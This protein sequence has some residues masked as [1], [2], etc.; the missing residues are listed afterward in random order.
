MSAT[1][2][3]RLYAFQDWRL[4]HGIGAVCRSRLMS[5]MCY[6][7]CMQVKINVCSFSTTWLAL[8]VQMFM[9]KQTALSSKCHLALL[10]ELCQCQSE[11]TGTLGIQIVQGTLSLSV[12]QTVLN[13]FLA[14]PTRWTCNFWSEASVNMGMSGNIK[15]QFSVTSIQTPKCPCREGPGAALHVECTAILGPIWTSYCRG[16]SNVSAVSDKKKKETTT[17]RDPTMQRFLWAYRGRERRK[18][19]RTMMMPVLIQCVTLQVELRKLSALWLHFHTGPQDL[20]TGLQQWLKGMN[21]EPGC[22]SVNKPLDISD[23]WKR[24]LFSIVHKLYT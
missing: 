18:G 19:H 16:H 24:V 2:L 22:W 15:Q 12:A 14:H 23:L 8:K 7:G 11:I 10:V 3:G 6:R 20:M 17:P 13:Y 5:V 1:M 21:S 4:Q 9:W